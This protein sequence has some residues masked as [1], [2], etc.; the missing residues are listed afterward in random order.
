MPFGQL[1]RARS[2]SLLSGRTAAHV[3]SL[4]NAHPLT[5]ML[6]PISAASA[7]PPRDVSCLD[8]GT[9]VG[10]SYGSSAVASLRSARRG[11][12]FCNV[13]L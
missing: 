6:S 1:K 5:G 13:S 8:G 2:P 7:G 12:L 10:I 3:W 9:Y 11:S 4:V